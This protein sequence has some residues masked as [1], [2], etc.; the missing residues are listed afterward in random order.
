MKTLVA[1]ASGATGKHLVQRLLDMGHEVKVILRSSN[2]IPD[3]WKNNDKI[4]IIERPI[5]K[6]STKEMAGY[7]SDCQAAASCLGHNLNFKGMYGKPRKL[8]RD[9]VG[10]I[11]KANQDKSVTKPLKLVLMNT[12]GNRN[13]DLNEPIT[14]GER[15]VT[16]LIRVL[17]PPHSD[18]EAAA[19]YLRVSIG[20]DSTTTEWVVVRPDSLVN[21]DKVTDYFMEVSPIRSPIFNAGKTSRINVGDFMAKLVD[22]HRLWEQWKGNMPVIYNK[23]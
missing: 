9:A 17:L 10:L 21:N 23:E 3:T 19:D 15:I 2:N 14:L 11:C 6:I 22:G 5:N 16:G 12:T 13:R 4:H 8:V 20:Q 18:N 7:L 1:G